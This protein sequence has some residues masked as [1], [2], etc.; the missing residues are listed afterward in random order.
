MSNQDKIA[1]L[2]PLVGRMAQSLIDAMKKKHGVDILITCGYRS[3]VEQDRLY[4]QGRTTPGNI[5][6]NAKGG[7]SL[8]QFGVAFDCV[9][10][11]AGKPNWNSPYTITAQEAALIGLEHGDRGYTDLPHFQYRDGYSLEDF[12]SGKVD[13]SKFA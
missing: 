10:L 11:I 3:P 8:H 7:Q 13:W 9:P 5:V 2:K 12:Q 1:T 6:T 4:A